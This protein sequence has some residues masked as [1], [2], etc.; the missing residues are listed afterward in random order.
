VSYR[1]GFALYIGNTKLRGVRDPNVPERVLGEPEGRREVRSG[2]Q[3]ERGLSDMAVQKIYILPGGYLDIDRSIFLSN[4]DM[5][6][7]IKAPVYSILLMDPLGPI[8]IDLGLNPD[9]VREPEKAWGA[10]AKLIKPQLTEEDDV[11]FRLKELG[12]SVSDVKMV[13]LTHM[14]WDHTGALRFFT[15]CPIIVQRDE[16][17]FAF[18]PDPFLAAPYMPNHIE[19]P[20]NYQLMDGDGFVAP[21]VSVIKSPGHTPGHQSVLVR[22]H[23]GNYYLFPGDAVPLMENLERKVPLSNSFSAKQCVESLYHLEHLAQLLG[24]RIIASHDLGIYETL[25]KCPEAL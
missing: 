13:I 8:L 21:G 19:H 23:A 22:V 4:V 10:R 17:R 3:E 18:R 9:G 11:R 25:N 16:Y 15:H 7:I 5:G 24:A 6:R 14:H 20:L 12:L 2:L 1:I